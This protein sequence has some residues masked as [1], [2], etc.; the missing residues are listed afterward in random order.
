MGSAMGGARSLG[1]SE[2]IN[3][4]FHGPYA[5]KTVKI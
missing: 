4:L 2:K 1:D 5:R 3:G